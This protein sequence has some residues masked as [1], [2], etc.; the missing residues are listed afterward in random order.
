MGRSQNTKS[1]CAKKLVEPPKTAAEAESQVWSVLSS[2]A[3]CFDFGKWHSQARCIAS[4]TKQVRRG[5]YRVAREHQ[6]NRNPQSHSQDLV[7]F[8]RRHISRFGCERRK[9]ST[10]LTSPAHAASLGDGK[11]VKE[12]HSTI[13][14]VQA[15]TT[16]ASR[17]RDKPVYWVA[18]LS[19]QCAL[20]DQPARVVAGVCLQAKQPHPDDVRAALCPIEYQRSHLCNSTATHGGEDEPWAEEAGLRPVV[21]ISAASTGEDSTRKYQ[22][23]HSTLRSRL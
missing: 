22:A 12:K 2:Q 21:A 9:L 17:V 6:S 11:L 14:A 7:D 16:S 23:V 20:C 10:V 13:A 5:T 3:P 8:Y 19:L 1:V 15:T 4:T 18:E